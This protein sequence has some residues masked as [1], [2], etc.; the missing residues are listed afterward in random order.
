APGCIPVCAHHPAFPA[1]M[2]A[3][4]RAPRV[5]FID[6]E[7]A[8]LAGALQA[9]VVAILGSARCSAYAAETA[10]ALARGLAAADV[11][12]ATTSERGVA[13]AA[14]A[15]ASDL[16]GRAVMVATDGLTRGEARGGARAGTA[17]GT[18]AVTP[19]LSEL[20]PG[21]PGRG[22]GVVA[23]QR[24]LV[25][26]SSLVV[27]VEARLLPA[28]MLAPRLALWWP[29]PVAAVPGRTD[30]QGAAGPHA[31]LRRGVPLVAGPEDVLALLDA[32]GRETRT[33][34]DV[35]GPAGHAA[36]VLERVAGGD[37]TV[38]GLLAHGG[39]R[40]ATLLALSELEVLG[41]LGRGPTGRYVVSA[42]AREAQGASADALL[43][44]LKQPPGAADDR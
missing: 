34:G 19:T 16:S 44:P 30:A 39:D 3:D 33:R 15:G 28:E 43:A 7:P 20:P 38:D 41:L 26:L 21:C 10:R 9:P 11:T 29:R 14:R 4:A 17:P 23:A 8:R 13:A 12:V 25:A 40:A 18:R 31:L 42:R 35:R 32:S 37:D 36:S 24:A 2:R 6:V 1:A 5:L 22:H 27:V